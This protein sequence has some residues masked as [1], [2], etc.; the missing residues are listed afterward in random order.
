MNK[1]K[2]LHILGD[3]NKGGVLSCLD[4]SLESGEFNNWDFIVSS[5]TEAPAIVATWKPDLIVIHYACSWA[6]FPQLLFYRKQAKVLIHEHN[7]CKAYM[8]RIPSPS[9]LKL[10]LKLSYAFSN[11]AV[12][13]S[14]AQGQWML[15]NELIS[16]DKLQVI[17]QCPQLDKF[18]R[19]KP[20]AINYP[21]ALGAY[22]RFCP[23]K[24]FDVL[25]QA[26]KLIPHAPI[27]LYIGG[28]G[29]DEQELQ[30][31]AQGLNNVKFVGRIDDVPAFLQKCDVVVI[32]SRWEPWGNVFLEAKAAGKPVIASNV[33]G[34]VEQMADCGILVPP[35]SPEK[36]AAAIESVIALPKSQLETWG[37]NG[38]ESVRGAWKEYLYQWKT[39][40]AEMTVLDEV[41]EQE[42]W[43]LTAK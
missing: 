21:F 29:A 7:Y 40:L 13:V 32:P 28:E 4:T 19:I 35:N 17:K 5:I 18:F 24:G 3:R 23:Q 25:L 33:D 38:R 16:P 41:T 22:G 10:I 14:Q 2:I 39:L 42:S 30:Q 36:L 6:R 15:E 11:K 9:R 37:Q 20:K 31:L 8:Q 26:I 34:L 27:E 1:K 12:A 43:M